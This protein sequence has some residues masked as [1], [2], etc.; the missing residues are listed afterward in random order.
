[1][2]SA[3]NTSIEYYIPDDIWKKIIQ[4]F[5]LT[6]HKKYWTTFKRNDKILEDITKRNV[7]IFSQ[8]I[9]NFTTDYLDKECILNAAWFPDYCCKYYATLETLQSLKKLLEYISNGIHVL[10]CR[11][12]IVSKYKYKSQRERYTRTVKDNLF[13][14]ER[15]CERQRGKNWEIWTEKSS[16]KTRGKILQLLEDN[17]LICFRIQG[18][19]HGWKIK[20][21]PYGTYF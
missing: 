11:Y 9:L 13:V 19:I 5:L 8:N 6:N 21:D 17:H 15:M 4:E 1:M 18:D 14:I 7:D 12:E 10:F 2:N 16:S 20:S 3:E